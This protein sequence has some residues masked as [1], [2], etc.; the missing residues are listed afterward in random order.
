MDHVPAFIGREAVYTLGRFPI[1]CRA[2]TERWTSNHAQIHTYG[3][4]TV[5]SPVNLTWMPLDCG[6]KQTYQER[7]NT[8]MGRTQK[9]PNWLVDLNP[10]P[11]CCEAAM[12][13][14]VMS[15]INTCIL[16]CDQSSFDHKVIVDYSM[17]YFSI[18]SRFQTDVQ[19]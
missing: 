3:Q 17:L 7:A 1:Y 5:E 8:T 14:S 15:I 16:K 4:F 2:N 19:I 11:S 9:G 10:R 13:P 12:L 18:V 6:R